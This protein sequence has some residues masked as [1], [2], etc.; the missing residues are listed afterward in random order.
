[1]KQGKSTAMRGEASVMATAVD[2][3]RKK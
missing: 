1:L 3:Q 2:D